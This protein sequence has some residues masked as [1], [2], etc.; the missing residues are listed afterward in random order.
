MTEN[1]DKNHL[2]SVERRPER[3]GAYQIIDVLGEGGMA[4]VY[5]AEQTEPVKRR[6]A[7][8]IL[9]AGMDSK[10][11]V[12]RFE[13]ER[14]AL[15]VLDHPNIA[16]IFDG[17]MAE[18]G[19]PYFA[20]E[21][22]KGL[23][24][25]DYC[26]D[27]RL[28]NEARIQLF[29]D[30]CAAVQHAH[31]K[32][33][34]HRDLKPSNILVSVVDGKPQP[35]VIDFGIAK[36]TTTTLTGATLYTKVGE[37]IGTPQYMSPEQAGVTGL[38]VD[39]RTDIYSLG[40]IL[41]ELLV[42]AAPL[43]L[44]GI[45]DQAMQIALKEKDPPTPSTRYTQ[46]DDTK[47]EIA[48]VRSTDPDDLGRQLTGDLD[49]VVMKA[50]EKDRTRRYE[51]VNALA[52]ECRRYLGHEPV[53]ARP[54]STGYL[55]SRFVQRN[56]VGVAAA[57]IAFGAIVA[58]AGL[59]TVGMLRALDAQQEAESA[60]DSTNRVLDAM[61][62]LVGDTYATLI[63]TSEPLRSTDNASILQNE[64]LRHILNRTDN[65]VARTL[66]DQPGAS[67][68][69]M[70]LQGTTNFV[71]GRYKESEEQLETA[72]AKARAAGLESEQV[73]LL[74]DLAQLTQRTSELEKS[75]AY[76]EQAR[77][78]EVYVRLPATLHAE[79]EI[80]AGELRL[81]ENEYD[82]A[83]A[84]YA[85]AIE[86]LESEPEISLLLAE[87]YWR[88]ADAWLLQEEIPEAQPWL[89]KSIDIYIEL[90]GP[91]FH[92]LQRIYSAYGWTQHAT[93][94]YSTALENFQRAH[95]VL[96]RNFGA[97]HPLVSNE[98]NNMAM[99]LNRL[100][101]YDEAV[102][103]YEKALDLLQRVTPASDHYRLA[104]FY[105]NLG[106]ANANRGEM[107]AATQNFR[108]GLTTVALKDPPDARLTAFLN[109]NLGD[110]LLNVGEVDAGIE[111]LREAVRIK[112]EIFGDDSVSAAR[113]KLLLA[114]GLAQLSQFES[115]GVLLSEAAAVYASEYSDQPHMLAF[116]VQTEADLEFEQGRLGSALELYVEA[117][118]RRLEKSAD[119]SRGTTELAGAAVA[120]ARVLS[121]QGKTD[122]TLEWLSRVDGTMSDLAPTNPVRI[123]AGLLRLENGDRSGDQLATLRA[124]I[125]SQYPSRSD[126][127]SR[128]D[129]LAN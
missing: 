67:V 4:E 125:A 93:G 45:G 118:N 129:A 123:E 84:R 3:I 96:L 62:E 103:T 82:G 72:L 110:H 37:I 52:M 53:L 124:A 51:T 31:H 78:L 90:E 104:G 86:L 112:T 77:G 55:V 6:V 71:L 68:R 99:S 56:R 33:L 73:Q 54:P 36:A 34:I 69:V 95:N 89:E 126:W 9:K 85:R 39:M 79:A 88:V 101:R 48:R 28:G 47:E 20:M 16:K 116:L 121:E 25:T 70:R 105:S 111:H 27:H 1:K 60:R 42:G 43:D 44:V 97:E 115:A 18:N 24:I 120:V 8:K 49:W 10:Q 29:I 30:V 98:L 13:S 22:V 61:I 21:H 87:A 108:D 100:G 50:I 75:R 63:R 23:P 114:Q 15:A 109:N 17:G 40:V 127:D 119:N 14:Q 32:G 94:N 74:I 58:G 57:V 64:P 46:L 7:L 41:Y 5:L 107:Q 83:R 91:D 59:A 35:K 66:V 81:L 122:D 26:D 2:A 38:D 65:M 117:Y 92:A 19:R 76:L 12:A 113:S 11:V 102:A 128:L 106:N 80:V